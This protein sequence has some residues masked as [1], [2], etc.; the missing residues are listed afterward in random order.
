MIATLYQWGPIQF[1]IY[2]LNVHQMDHTTQSD[3][4][5]K[6]IA[7]AAQYREWVGEGDDEITLR[8]RVFPHYM[9]EKIRARGSNINSSGG[10]GHLDVLDNMRRLGQAHLLIRGDGYKLGW[11][12]LEK[13][14]RGH[15]ELGSDG[16]GQQIDF[17]GSFQRVPVP[18]PDSYFAFLWGALN[19]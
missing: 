10:L 11:Y 1:Q 9:A 7:G 8:G 2:P 15:T 3:W 18:N 4:A 19:G 6:E 13:L 5:R 17:Q 14:S 12:I 16:I